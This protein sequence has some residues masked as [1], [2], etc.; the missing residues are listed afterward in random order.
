MA[1][2][3]TM[4]YV[5]H[6]DP[7]LDVPAASDKER[8]SSLVE[9]LAAVNDGKKPVTDLPVREGRRL[10]VWQMRR[11]SCRGYRDLARVSLGESLRALAKGDMAT[12]NSRA[13]FPELEDAV[14]R[15]VVAVEGWENGKGPVELKTET[16]PGDQTVLTAE[17]MEQVF[18]EFGAR[19]VG[20]LGDRILEVS[21]M[22]PR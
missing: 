16:A 4:T 7:A 19:I 1:A 15:G 20:E 18:A 5:S 22:G 14:R 11:L 8:V 3:G 9:L 17:T 13:T 12:M 21:E 10:V 2:K 6:R